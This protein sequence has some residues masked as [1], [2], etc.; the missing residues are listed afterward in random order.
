[1]DIW[2]KI[3]VVVVFCLLVYKEILKFAANNSSTLSAPAIKNKAG[4]MSLFMVGLSVGLFVYVGLSITNIENRDL[5]S[6]PSVKN[7]P[8]FVSIFDQGVIEL[9]GLYIKTNLAKP[10]DLKDLATDLTQQCHG[11]DACEINKMFDYVTHIPYRTDHTS[12]SPKKVLQT[13]WGDCDDKSNLFASL[14][15][16]RGFD[17]RFVYV[18]HHVFVVVHVED[19]KSLP[20]LSARLTI[21]GKKYYYAETT[22]A[23]SH[24]GEFNGQFPYA[25]EG[26]Y[27]IKNN[28]AVDMDKVSFRMM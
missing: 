18:P 16:E 7:A 3:A 10:G 12:R 21:N 22:A 11:N 19:E 8:E 28:E 25:F 9:N 2:V 26:I 27:D 13:N 5:R 6:Y 15:N 17:Y 23:G 20:F 14:L 1:M 4:P 24:I